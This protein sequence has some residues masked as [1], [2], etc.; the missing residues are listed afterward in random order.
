MTRGGCRGAVADGY[1]RC[2]PC[3][4]HHRVAGG[5]IADA[6]VPIAYGISGEQHYQ[7][8]VAYQAKYP[9]LS[10]RPGSGTSRCSSYVN[11]G[12]ASP[13][14]PVVGSPTWRSSRVPAVGLV[15]T[16]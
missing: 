1:T 9:A 2:F 6:V 4:E 16:H 5:W 7:N 8:L 11:T 15:L 14:P 10:A 3:D 13:K 12:S